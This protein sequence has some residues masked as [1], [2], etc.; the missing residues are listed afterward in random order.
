MPP[1]QHLPLHRLEQQRP[2]KKPRFPGMPLDPDYSGHGRRVRDEIGRVVQAQAARP[3]IPG[4]APELILKVSLSR[5]INEDEW[6]KAGF[7]V[8]AQNPGNVFVLFADNRELKDFLAKLEA[9]Q[10]GPREGAK[11][12]PNAGL[13][14]YIVAADEVAAADRIGPHLRAAGITAPEGIDGRKAF[15]VDIELWDAGPQERLARAN[16]VAAY[17]GAAGR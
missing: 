4:I 6:R 10:K 12:P 11:T 17:P 8:V 1:R 5:S 2:R 16:F 13:I 9:F 3:Q 14:G 15:V 7:T